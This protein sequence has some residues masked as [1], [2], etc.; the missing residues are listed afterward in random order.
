MRTFPSCLKPMKRLGHDAAELTAQGNVLE[1]DEAGNLLD[2][3]GGLLQ[4][5]EMGRPIRPDH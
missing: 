2:Q 3:H 5:D 4:T 1:V